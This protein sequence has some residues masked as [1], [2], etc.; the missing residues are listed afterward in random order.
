[1]KL[2]SLFQS[3]IRQFIELDN[4][5][6]SVERVLEYTNTPQEAALESPLGNFINKKICIYKMFNPKIFIL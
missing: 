2:V 3:G 4:Q 6:T 1:M 5:M